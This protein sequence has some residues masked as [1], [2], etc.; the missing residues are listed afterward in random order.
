MPSEEAV[1]GAGQEATAALPAVHENETVTSEVF[2]PLGFGAGEAAAVIVGGVPVSEV[3]IEPLLVTPPTVTLTAP[4]VAP[5]GTGVMM[6]VGLQLV[7]EAGTPLK[8][9]VLEPCVAPKFVPVIITDVPGAPEFGDRLAM[10]GV[11]RN[12]KFAELLAFPTA[13][14]TTGPVV[15][16]L[17]TGTVI[18]ESL[19][20]VGEAA[21]PLKVIVLAP[22]ARPKVVPAI[23]TVDPAGPE[24]GERLRMFGSTVKF[25]VLLAI[26][27]TASASGPLLEPAGMA[28]V[29]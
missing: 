8:V 6:D 28:T 29:I 27:P 26:P 3:N 12:V 14:T 9:T 2:Q 17:G 7:G 11:G 23:V 5:L 1:C 20:L 10:L 19:Q 4:V 24:A 22:C 15:A 18:W 13:V 21:E 25:R 16:L